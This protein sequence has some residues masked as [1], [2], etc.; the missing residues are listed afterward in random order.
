MRVR[1]YGFRWT[2]NAPFVGPGHV[3]GSRSTPAEVQV[4]HIWQHAINRRCAAD[5]SPLYLLRIYRQFIS[6]S[7]EH[8]HRVYFTAQLEVRKESWTQP[9]IT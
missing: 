4:L 5:S 6:S 7:A 3:Q 1:R 2:C 8:S 9:I